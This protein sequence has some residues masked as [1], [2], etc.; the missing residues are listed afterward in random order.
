MS[1]GSGVLPSE[2]HWLNAALSVFAGSAGMLAP[3]DR[4]EMLECEVSL[5]M[6]RVPKQHQKK[7]QYQQIPSNY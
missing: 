3:S 6:I 5:Y 2:S 1:A 4:R 7:Q